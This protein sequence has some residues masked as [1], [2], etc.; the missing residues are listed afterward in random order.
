MLVFLDRHI[1]QENDN[2]MVKRIL[3]SEI[4]A[5]GSRLGDLSRHLSFA[6]Q[7][8]NHTVRGDSRN[9]I[10][11]WV[12]DET[13]RKPPPAVGEI[14]TRYYEL[15]R[16]LCV[17]Q[18]TTPFLIAKQSFANSAS[19]RTH[20]DYFRWQHIHTRDYPQADSHQHS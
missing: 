19:I 8:S 16:H 17:R 11:T 1:V 18:L 14:Q 6:R 4:G 10:R 2:G 13:R 12:L 15:S 20:R 7:G 5:R 9:Y 3:R